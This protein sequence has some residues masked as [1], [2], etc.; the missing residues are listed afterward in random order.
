M[1]GIIK[2]RFYG[3]PDGS[4]YPQWYKPGDVV[5]GDLARSAIAQGMAD[6]EGKTIEK[7]PAPGAQ[8]SA[9]QQGQASR[10]QTAKRRVR[11]GKQSRSTTPTG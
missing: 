8:S 9:S 2:Y 7:K 6:E 5:T 3:A 4:C 11:S 1:R 10:K